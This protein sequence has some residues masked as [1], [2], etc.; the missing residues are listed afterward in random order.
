M[1][2]HWTCD[3]NETTLT[4]SLCKAIIFAANDHYANYAFHNL[5]RTNIYGLVIVHSSSCKYGSK[6][7]IL[8]LA[9]P[10]STKGGTT[11]LKVD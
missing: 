5:I 2:Y 11:W 6:L 3:N 10:I 8:L 1:L 7:S 4:S 9:K